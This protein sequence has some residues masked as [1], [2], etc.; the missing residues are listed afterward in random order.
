MNPHFTTLDLIVLAA[1]FAGTMAVGF[2]CMRRSGSVEGFTAAGRSLPGWLTGLSILGTY[3][4]SIS[5]LALPGKAF[6][7]N[8]NPFVFSLSLPLATWIGVKWFVPFYRAQGSVSAFAHL[9]QRFGAWARGYAAVF[10]LLTQLA[11]MG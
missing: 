6:A 2:V 5:F 11:R 1:Y 4:S 3:V 10:Y 9:E 8:W 7:S